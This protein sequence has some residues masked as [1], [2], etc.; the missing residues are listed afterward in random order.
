VRHEALSLA[1]VVAALGAAALSGAHRGGALVGAGISGATGLISLRA[2][3]H[4]AGRAEKK[5]Q[6]ALMVVALG[7]LV[8]LLLVSLG[9]VLV[10]KEGQSVA[11]FVLAFFVV[12]F[13]LAGIE[14]AYVQRLGR[15]SGAPA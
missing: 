8:R 6:A 12:Y 3:G 13:I 2:M 9:T 11:G 5:V 4:F 14:G 15:R 10:V 7:F 1:V